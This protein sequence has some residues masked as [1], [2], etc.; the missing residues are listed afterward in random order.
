LVPLYG[1]EEARLRAGDKQSFQLTGYGEI[2]ASLGDEWAD[3]G[4]VR[5]LAGAMTFA[6]QQE[7]LTSVIVE[8]SHGDRLDELLKADRLGRPILAINDRHTFGSAILGDT[9]SAHSLGSFLNAFIGRFATETPDDA[10]RQAFFRQLE[11]WRLA[12]PFVELHHF[13]AF[14]AL[15]LLA[16]SNG[17]HAANGNAAV[18]IT[19]IL[20]RHGFIASQVEIETW[21]KARNEA[22][23]KGQLVT[24]NPP[25]P[26][27]RL[28]EQVVP[29]TQVL[30][31][32][33]LKLL[34]FDD[35][36]I[37]WNRWRDRM[38]FC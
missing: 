21:C 24:P 3:S 27:I 10:L 6:Q 19:D 5:L 32:I 26:D 11:I 35:G 29:I 16:R 15:E 18:P 12:T 2:T 36:H 34:P 7:I 28:T 8:M 33:L 9:W 1:Y 31:D 38:A 25:G 37:N 30:C 14:S 13:L 17:A 4:R 20:N 23:H 22:F